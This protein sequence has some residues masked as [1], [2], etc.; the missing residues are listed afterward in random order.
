MI[1]VTIDLLI[2]K[3]LSTKSKRV[4]PGFWGAPAVITTRSAS[5]QSE[6]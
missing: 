4:S 5:E 6:Y 3:F 1:S 2:A